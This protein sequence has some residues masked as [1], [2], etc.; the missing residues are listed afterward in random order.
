MQNNVE[1]PQSRKQ[2]IDIVKGISMLLV[3]LFHT[4]VYYPIGGGTHL[5][6]FYSFFMLP[7]FFIVSGYLFSAG[8]K[9]F[10]LRKKIK[11]IFRGIIWTYLV[12]TVIIWI[13]KA[14]VNETSVIQGL[15]EIMLGW[16]SW[17]VVA[18]GV[19]ELIFA[20]LLRYVKKLKYIA[21]YIV[22]ALI[23]SYLIKLVY[24]DVLPFHF[25]LALIAT[26][27]LG[28]GF[29]YRIYEVQIHNFIKVN[30]SSLF[31]FI[32]LYSLLVFIDLK[33]IHTTINLYAANEYNH[34]ILYFIYAFIGTM[35]LFL[36]A[37]LVHLPR[38]LGKYLCFVGQN[39]LI[40]YYLNTGGIK[41]LRMVFNKFNIHLPEEI[42][43]KW[44]FI[45]ILFMYI[46]ICALTSVTVYLIKRYCPIMVGDKNSFN[47]V[48]QKL[49]LKISF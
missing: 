12:F 19:A 21:V 5:Y 1:Q 36:F 44:G 39:S 46:C 43:L 8:N 23:L 33:Y 16:A 34:F 7:S 42:A 29:F 6:N 22:L 27:F 49:K 41:L 38:W 40:F 32:L 24:P 31:F 25:N 2:W 15:K 35:M 20:F 26:F 17:F 3:I 47:K 37:K 4:E 13:P 30:Y 48:A 9:N 45:E 10:S 14:I 28:I 18:L 11:S